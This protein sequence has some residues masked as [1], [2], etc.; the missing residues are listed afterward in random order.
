MIRRRTTTIELRTQK[1]HKARM[2]AM[3]STKVHSMPIPAMTA[4]NMSGRATARMT[5]SPA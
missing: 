1:T 5:P 4:Q 2:R 3:V